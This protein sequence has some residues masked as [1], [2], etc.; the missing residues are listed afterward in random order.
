MQR[1]PHVIQRTLGAIATLAFVLTIAGCSG[2]QDQTNAANT[3][4]L[5][6]VTT[7][8]TI[9]SFVIGVGG[10]RVHVVNIVPVG[11]SPETF[12]PT[13]QDVAT[14]SRAQLLVENG[15]GLESWLGRLL[16][17][18]RFAESQNGRGLRRLAG[19][20]QQPA[21]LDGPAVRQAVRA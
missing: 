15:A 10:D 3:G 19:Q 13:P 1:M 2:K 17:Q 8:S 18:C 21:P 6:V 7:I 5:E 14:V 20:E 9:N 16:E 12:Q 4:K 11:A